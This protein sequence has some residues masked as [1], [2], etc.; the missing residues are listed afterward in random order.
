MSTW[1][2]YIVR[3][4]NGQLY[5]GITTNVARRVKQHQV[6]SGAKA[7]RG[8]GP[9]ELMWSETVGNRSDASKIE[10]AIKQQRRDKKLALIEGT[11]L[12]TELLD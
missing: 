7:L 11:L 10:Y 8:K 1:W 6:G 4:G 12:V 5:T 2:V 9:I 3:N